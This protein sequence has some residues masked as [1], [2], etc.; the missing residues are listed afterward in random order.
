MLPCLIFEDEHLLVINKPAGLNTHSPSP[1]AGEGIYD[2][3]RNR[4]PRWANLAIVHRLDKDTSGVIVFTKT[5][6]AN[7][8]LTQQFTG[9]QVR[10]AYRLLTDH[11]PFSSSLHKRGSD[12]F[13]VRTKIARAGDKYASRRG[14]EE[15][16]THFRRVGA[17]QS[18]PV[19]VLELEAE[20]LTGRTHQIRVH[21]AEQ[22][23][24][25]LG[26]TLYGGTA[27]PRMCL[28]AGSLTFKHP[29]SG[30]QVRF[31]APV[32]FSAEPRLAL[33]LA[34][35]ELEVTDAFRLVHG[36]SDSHPGWYVDK[37]G[38]V[39]LSE[40]AEALSESQ[41]RAVESLLTR[42]GTRAAAHKILRRD[43]RE[44]SGAI[45]SPEPVGR[46]PLPEHFIVLE[47]GLR[48]EI[49]L[50]EGY[51]VGLFLDQRENRRR[52]LTGYIAP[53]FSTTHNAGRPLRLLNTFSYTCGFSVCAA[54]AGACTTSVDL[55]KK[56]LD[57]GRRNFALNELDP[58]A[59]D[60]IHGDTF[61]WL[62]R[63]SR[64]NRRFDLLLLDPPTF[65]QSKV[66]GVFRAEKDYS[67][68]VTAALPLLEAEGVL[69]ASCNTA[70]WGAAAFLEMVERA[71]SRSGR[72]ILQKQYIP[73]PPDFPVSR[74][75]PAY[76]KTV[77]LRLS[78]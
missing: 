9:R 8:S 52:L 48:F 35:I 13:M 55:S 27:A 62:R 24:P 33:R 14:G 77:W 74:E 70:G 28:H 7:R 53:G 78:K 32:D 47:N 68:L 38:P 4:E 39:L 73:Q 64:K 25:I 22:G 56:Y 46:E 11:D 29:C 60:F 49:S 58:S 61:D 3:L 6:L 71:V 41:R 54:K 42:T 5:Q 76:L 20:P 21:A 16:V 40:S 37:L 67:N 18:G 59:H 23:F 45:A 63:L 2:W 26:D 51:S 65:S 30:E 12:E 10:K 57:W 44:A 36:A 50:A 66:S 72:R 34:L 31:E 43:V 19:P 17:A 75:E 15:A 69:F 1:F